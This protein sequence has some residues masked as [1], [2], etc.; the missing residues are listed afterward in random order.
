[1]KAIREP[2]CKNYF[3]PPHSRADQNGISIFWV[4][5][6]LKHLCESKSEL[7]VSLRSRIGRTSLQPDRIYNNVYVCILCARLTLM[8]RTLH[9]EAS[10]NPRANPSQ[11]TRGSTRKLTRGSAEKRG[12]L[13]FIGFSQNACA[14]FCAWNAQDRLGM[15]TRRTKIGHSG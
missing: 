9:S 1:M 4:A 11:P 2:N 8:K 6:H 15:A 10:T 12:S 13:K 14:P 5:N 3:T 7:G